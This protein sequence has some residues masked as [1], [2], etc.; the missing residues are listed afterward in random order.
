MT[1]HA[2]LRDR[3]RRSLISRDFA[4]LWSGQ[5]ISSLGTQLTGNAIPLIAILN[6]HATAAQVSFLAVL[7]LLPFIFVSLPAGALVDRLPRRGVMQITDIGRALI[8]SCIPLAALLG[9]LSMDVLAITFFLG[10][11]LSVFF[12]MAYHAYVPAL[13]TGK[14][15]LAGN[16]RLA[17]SESLA[18]AG[19]PALSG[20]LVQTVG[21]P[22]AIAI[23]AISF[24]ISAVSLG[25]IRRREP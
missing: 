23:D 20:T 18:E 21:G 3:V 15:L 1:S 9:V 17:A 6:L 5:T 7:G 2:S 8:L 12:E 25:M 4:L 11:T 14:R 13:L 10:Q 24:V 19:G 22:F 16:S